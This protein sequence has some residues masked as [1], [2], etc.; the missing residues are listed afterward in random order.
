M[1]LQQI[2]LAGGLVVGGVVWYFV[3]VRKRVED[4]SALARYRSP[5][6]VEVEVDVD[7]DIGAGDDAPATRGGGSDD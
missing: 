4:T 7:F 1:D 3:Y 2:L 6:A 5:P